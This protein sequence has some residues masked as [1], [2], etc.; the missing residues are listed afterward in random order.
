M[1]PSQNQRG[2]LGLTLIELLVVI[3]VIAILAGILLPSFHGTKDK[4]PAT[5]CV[6]QLKQVTLGEII[7]ANDNGRETLPAQL[8]TN[9]GGFQAIVLQAGLVRYYTLLSNELR[10]PRILACPTDRRRPVD[11][12]ALFTTNHLSYF[13]NV[14]A[15]LDTNMTVAIH[16]DRQI[17]FSPR[18]RG[19]L[20]TLATDTT[21]RW[22]KDVHSSGS[23]NISHADGSV[24]SVS[25][26][27][28]IEEV[29][30]AGRSARHRLV[31]P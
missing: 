29:F 31:F 1:N 5:V 15:G 17:E 30:R 11:E 18:A 19:P 6:N 20:V 13:L 22:A 7:W 3:A 2:R 28:A 16:G 9:V 8:S 27:T 23:G 25:N 14:D 10:S 26:G 12:F 4:A 21:M 24:E